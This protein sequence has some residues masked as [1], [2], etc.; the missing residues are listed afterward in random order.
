[1]RKA[2]IAPYCVALAIGNC[3]VPFILS[4]VAQFMGEM[5]RHVFGGVQMLA[6]CTRWALA[7]PSWFYVFTLL[8]I[9]ACVGL[10][11][12][13][14]SVSLLLH[15]VLAVCIIECTALFFFAVGIC[16]NLSYT[17]KAGS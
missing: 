9:L 5:Y 3:F 14:V 11:V 15:G 4:Q 12:R 1:M 10:F 6:G 7:L 17:D 2:H 8:S 13:R 16:L